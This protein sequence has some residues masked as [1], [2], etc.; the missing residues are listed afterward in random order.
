MAELVRAK[1]VYLHS[2]RAEVEAEWHESELDGKRIYIN[3]H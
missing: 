3:I 1:K 2:S